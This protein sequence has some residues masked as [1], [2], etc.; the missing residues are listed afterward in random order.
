MKYKNKKL[1]IEKVSIENI[2][3]KYNTPTYCYSYNQL[4]LNIK[5]FKNSFE[6]FSPLICFAVKSNTNLNLIREIKKFGLGADVVSKGELM[7]AIKAGINP[8]KIVLNGDIIDFW[9]FKKRNWD[10]YHTKA[11][12][13]LVE[14]ISQGVQVYYIAGN[15]DES[16][17]RFLNFEMCR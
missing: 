8:K 13:K 6:S 9:Q 2:A 12:K 16:F 1:T 15:H 5:N 10:K 3:K 14:F 4:K 11:I 17:R 7:M